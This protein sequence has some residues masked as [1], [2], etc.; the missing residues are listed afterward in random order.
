MNRTCGEFFFLL[1]LLLFKKKERNRVWMWLGVPRRESREER[2]GHTSP[3]LSPRAG[4]IR[5]SRVLS[6]TRWHFYAWTW[7]AFTGRVHVDHWDLSTENLT[8]S[9]G[10]PRGRRTVLHLFPCIWMCVSISPEVS[11]G[12]WA[13][14]ITP[15]S[16]DHI[17]K[18]LSEPASFSME[19]K[20]FL[21]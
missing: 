8:V 12:Q 3:G 21:S 2:G 17:L 20:H 1:L 15:A 4:E 14:A 10:F 16:S 11:G 18:V 5:T 13:G 6:C 7:G 19:V 9:L